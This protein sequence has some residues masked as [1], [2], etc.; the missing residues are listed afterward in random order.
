LTGYVALNERPHGGHRKLL[1]HAAGA[2]RVLDVGCSSGY[3]SAELARSGSTV[4]GI[5]VDPAAAAEAGRCCERVLVGDVEAMDLSA[6]EPASFDA[7]VCGDVVEHLRDPCAALARL[8]PLL[9]TDGKLVLTTPNVANWTL[10][11]S[12]LFGRWRYTSR[13][14]LDRGHVHLFTRATLVECVEAAG[15]RVESVDY[16]VP[17]PLVGT[18]PVERLA[19]GLARLRPPLFAY[20]FVLVARAPCSPS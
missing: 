13:G 5:D 14:L 18:A 15:Y 19:H 17:V 3:L 1:A 20:Q 4:V 6:L 8:R 9:R 2:G 12:L 16:T 10:R 7:I 11:L